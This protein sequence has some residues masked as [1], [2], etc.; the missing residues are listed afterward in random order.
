MESYISDLPTRRILIAVVALDIALV[1][2]GLVLYPS[3]IQSGGLLGATGAIL[4]VCFLGT[5]ALFSPISIARAHPSLWRTGLLTGTIAGAWLGLDL[6][7]NYFIYRDGPTNSK[8]S[9][10]VYGVYFLLMLGTAVRG[11]LLTKRFRDGLT[12]GLWF[13]IAAQLIWFTVEFG[14][15]YLFSRTAVGVQFIQTEMGADFI[16]SGEA[17]FQSFVISDFYGA[18]FFHLLLIGLVAVLLIGSIGAGAGRLIASRQK[19]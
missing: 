11:A 10:V 12:A 9:L 17:N 14:A 3:A 13:V 7:L 6:V 8:I 16:R 18:G 4:M 1:L 19:S 2:L 15:Y 5:L